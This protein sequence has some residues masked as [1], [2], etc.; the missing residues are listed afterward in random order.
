MFALCILAAPDLHTTPWDIAE[1]PFFWLHQLF[2]VKAA[3]RKA[4]N[5]KTERER[6]AAERAA[7]LNL[8][9]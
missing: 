5:R 8:K 9:R 3:L 7:K 6:Y 1:R 2:L 4:E